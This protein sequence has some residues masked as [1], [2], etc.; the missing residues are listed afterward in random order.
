MLCKL[1]DEG[2]HAGRLEERL[3]AARQR[4]FV[5]R[6]EELATFDE[7][8]CTGSKVL[9]IHG[10]GG[11]G[12]SALLGRFAQRAA[13]ADRTILVLDGRMLE[14]SPCSLHNRGQGGARRRAGGAADRRLR[15]HPWSGELAARAVP[16]GAA[17]RRAG[18]GGWSHTPGHDVAG[19]PGLGRHG[20]DHRAGRAGAHERRRTAGLPPCGR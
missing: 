9:L 4:A 5:G 7:A 19:R 20:A 1:V 8:L 16:A 13:V 2:Q 14:G 17:N 3:Q 11:V 10:P 6:K 18:C 12:K 15:T